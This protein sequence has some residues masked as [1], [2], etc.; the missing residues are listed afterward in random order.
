MVGDLYTASIIGTTR[1][2]SIN[3]HLRIGLQI[4]KETSKIT[5]NI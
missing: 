4:L 2:R 5:V 1:Y 3:M